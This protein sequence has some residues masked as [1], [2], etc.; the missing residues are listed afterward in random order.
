MITLYV[1]NSGESKSCPLPS[2]NRD[3]TTL[4]LNRSKGNHLSI[5]HPV[6]KTL[7]NVYQILGTMLANRD[8]SHSDERIFKLKEMFCV[9]LRVVIPLPAGPLRTAKQKTAYRHGAG[10]EQAQGV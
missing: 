5:I 6:S 4:A 8:S 9:L 7:L 10:G 3:T 1:K 2:V